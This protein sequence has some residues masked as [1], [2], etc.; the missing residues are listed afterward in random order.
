[1]SLKKIY[2]SIENKYYEF[3]E[4]TGLYK[5]TD[6]IDR[7]MPSMVFFLLL[8]IIIVAGILFFVSGGL[9]IGVG[10]NT[11]S[12]K[13]L[14]DGIPTELRCRTVVVWDHEDSFI[15][16]GYQEKGYEHFASRYQAPGVLHEIL[17]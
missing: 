11:V 8:L 9:T 5:I 10:E 13:V 6:K 12:F 3:V 16:D 15:P 14:A 7:F 2:Y 17:S 1:M 4:K